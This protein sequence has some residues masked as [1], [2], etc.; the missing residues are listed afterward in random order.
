MTENPKVGLDRSKT[1]RA[2][3][4]PNK[5]TALLKDAILL[6]ATKAGGKDGLVG[7]LEIQAAANPGPF[8]ALL[9]K[10]LPMQIAGDPDSPI[11]HEVIRRIVRPSDPN[12]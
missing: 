12:G 8:M 5:T 4:T 1:G 7:Y 11:V 3:G 6:A 2:K 10:V 9:G